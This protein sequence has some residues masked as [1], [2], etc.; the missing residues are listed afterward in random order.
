[1]MEMVNSKDVVGRKDKMLL[2][3]ADMGL[4]YICQNDMYIR[5]AIEFRKGR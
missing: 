2:F 4:E 1:M 3:V 5:M